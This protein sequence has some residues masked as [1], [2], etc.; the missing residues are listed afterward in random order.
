MI[1]TIFSRYSWIRTSVLQTVSSWNHRETIFSHYCENIN[2]YKLF[3]HGLSSDRQ[4]QYKTF[5][6]AS[7]TLNDSKN[8]DIIFYHS[9]AT[10]CQISKMK[11]LVCI[12]THRKHGHQAVCVSRNM[13]STS[14]GKSSALG[15]IFT[16][17]CIHIWGAL[18]WSLW[19]PNTSIPF[20]EEPVWALHDKTVS[21]SPRGCALLLKA[22]GSFIKLI[23][24]RKLF[25]WLQ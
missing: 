6:R 20:W 7:K 10:P 17:Q 12:I 11:L 23:L 8:M 25:D 15:G 4:K 21:E 9:T 2:Y 1:S 18:Y 19:T 22:N 13:M 3:N 16:M 5:Q 14:E 24:N